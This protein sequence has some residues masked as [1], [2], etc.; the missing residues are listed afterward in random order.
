MCFR[1]HDSRALFV[2]AP[3]NDRARELLKDPDNS[4][5][6]VSEEV[7]GFDIGHRASSSG[8][9]STL[10]T[11]GRAGDI[12]LRDQDTLFVRDPRDE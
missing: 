9:L 3:S 1:P 4:P 2:L 6:M 10:A 7:L 12:K 8:E 5:C 11:I